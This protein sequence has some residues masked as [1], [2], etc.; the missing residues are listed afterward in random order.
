ML[1]LVVTIIIVIFVL[2][3][4]KL[5]FKNSYHYNKTTLLKLSICFKD[6]RP[7][8]EKRSRYKMNL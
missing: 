7:K 2:D 5:N 6:N 8:P 1:K 4:S 3:H